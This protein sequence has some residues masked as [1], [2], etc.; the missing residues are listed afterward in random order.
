MRWAAATGD[1]RSAPLWPV[2]GSTSSPVRNRFLRNR[3]S[4][5][6]ESVRVSIDALGPLIARSRIIV[7]PLSAPWR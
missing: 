4:S 3:P 6:W 5:S 2:S 1:S 7:S